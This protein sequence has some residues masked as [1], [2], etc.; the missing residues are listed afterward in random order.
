MQ[1]NKIYDQKINWASMPLLKRMVVVQT[2]IILIF[3]ILLGLIIYGFWIQRGEAA[4]NIRKVDL[5]RIMSS[6]QEKIRIW[7]SLGMKEAINLALNDIRKI[8]DIS[9]VDVLE[10]RREE[11]DELKENEKN[12]II[13][14]IYDRD[15]PYF[16]LIEISVADESKFPT[17]LAFSFLVCVFVFS[18]TYFSMRFVLR[19]ILYPLSMLISDR[20]ELYTSESFDD[21]SAE[22]E[23]GILIKK[24]IDN[25]KKRVSLESEKNNYKIANQLAHDIRSPLEILKTIKSEFSL[26]PDSVRIRA[27]LSISRIDE[28]AE[29]LLSRHK[30]DVKKFQ[31]NKPESLVD[32]LNDVISEK[33]I[34]YELNHSIIIKDLFVEKANR[35]FLSR[36]NRVILKGVLSNI[37]NNSIESFGY[38]PGEVELVLRSDSNFHHIYIK[39]NGKGIPSE[40]KEKIFS[41]GV[42]TKDNGN[43]LGLYNAKV[44][45]EDM[46]GKIDVVSQPGIGT[47]FIIS[48]P[49]FEE[50]EEKKEDLKNIVLIDDDK[51]VQ[52]NWTY[53]CQEKSIPIRCFYSIQDFI[54]HSSLFDFNTSIYIDSELKENERGEIYSKKIYDLGFKKLYIVTGYQ[55]NEIVKP[56][57]IIDLLSKSPDNILR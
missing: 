36:V 45:I 15:V 25:Q 24:V 26:L 42:S 1:S 55:K 33:R 28:I 48:F 51:L 5:V 22:G 2:S 19:K 43:G 30:K 38:S 40:L 44:D 3:S 46:N 31:I 14:E 39:D 20:E 41:Y 12:L 8:D 50:F 4:L 17:F 11:F 6:Q 35:L 27:L 9:A 52:I 32:V 57:W 16:I 49:S 37:I 21:I 13:P 10:L 34:E 56:D 53:F 23:I 18:I 47:S 54:E 29:S 7:A